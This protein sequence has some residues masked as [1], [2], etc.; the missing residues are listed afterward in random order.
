MGY[1][2]SNMIGIRTG[3][4]ASGD[5]DHADMTTRI[6]R[7]RDEVIATHPDI[8]KPPAHVVDAALSHEL[9]AGKGSYVVIAGVFNYWTYDAVSIFVAALSKEFGTEVMHMCWN[10][11]SEEVQCQVWLDGRPLFEVHEHPIGQILRRIA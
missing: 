7:I 11:E 9:T 2:V 4:V 6:G 1:Y 10:E 5:V 3:G 8:E